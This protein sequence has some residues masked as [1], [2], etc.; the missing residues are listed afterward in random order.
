MKNRETFTQILTYQLVKLS[1]KKIK[2]YLII[3]R[4]QLT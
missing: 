4:L 1:R 2:I 3:A